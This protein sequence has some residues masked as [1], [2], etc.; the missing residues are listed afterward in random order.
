MECGLLNKNIAYLFRR[1]GRLRILIVGMV[2]CAI[3]GLIKAF[4]RNYVWYLVV[5]VNHQK[6]GIQTIIHS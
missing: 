5:S 1:F 6:F 4:V 3:F 2:G